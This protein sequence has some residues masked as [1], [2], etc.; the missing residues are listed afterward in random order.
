M[1]PGMNNDTINLTRGNDPATPTP[2][3]IKPKPKRSG[4]HDMDKW[5]VRTL[6]RG[7]GGGYGLFFHATDIHERYW[8]TGD[9]YT[10][11]T[12]YV[13]TRWPKSGGARK[14]RDKLNK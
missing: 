5:E 4:E 2:A 3:D 13:A 14:M 9:G 6:P 11:L 1:V 10:A 12:P 8:Y 7:A